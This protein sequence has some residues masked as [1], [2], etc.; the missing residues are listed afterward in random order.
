MVKLK[1]AQAIGAR[2]ALVRLGVVVAFFLF[3]L[4]RLRAMAPSAASLDV[5]LGLRSESDVTHLLS[6]GIRN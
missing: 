2:V 4:C 5:L 1:V 6:L 3:S